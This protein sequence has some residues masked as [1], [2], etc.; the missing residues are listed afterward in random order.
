MGDNALQPA[1]VLHSRRYRESS[2]IVEFLTRDH[3]RVAALAKGV[4]GGKRPRQQLLQPF[5]PLLV[6]WR[7][8]GDLST[9]TA[10]EAAGPLRFPQGNTLYCGLYVNE[11]LLRLTQRGDPYSELFPAYALC[12]AELLQADNRNS[13]LEP[14]LRRFEVS[15]LQELGLGLSLT[16]DQQG[17]PLEP[18]LQYRYDFQSGPVVAQ[19]GE[20]TVRGSTLIGLNAG[21]L[22]DAQ[23]LLEARRLMRRVLAHHL[24]GQALKSRELFRGGRGKGATG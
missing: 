11:L 20:H 10:V 13:H 7:G 16:H 4:L 1:Y 15:L 3:G 6:A 9:L 14:A 22:A 19:A 17:R 2:L 23:E 18:A 5:V 12:L 21:E 8:L 24:G